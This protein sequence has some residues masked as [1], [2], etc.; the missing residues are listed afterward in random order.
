MLSGHLPLG[1]SKEDVLANKIVFVSLEFDEEEW[2][3]KV[4]NC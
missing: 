3:T 1:G 2:E 4:K